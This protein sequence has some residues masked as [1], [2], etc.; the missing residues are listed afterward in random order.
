ME[1]NTQFPSITRFPVSWRVFPIQYSTTFENNQTHTH[2][3]LNMECFFRAHAHTIPSTWSVF[4]VPMQDGSKGVEL[5]PGFAL[6]HDEN[7]GGIHMNRPELPVSPAFFVFCVD[8]HFSWAGMFLVLLIVLSGAV[9]LRSYLYFSFCQQVLTGCVRPRAS[10]TTG[11][12]PSI[13]SPNGHRRG[14]TCKRTKD[15]V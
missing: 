12:V 13:C 11:S 6:P 15:F 5:K 2:H 10:I 7:V 4:F 8:T 3:S 14:R 9:Y 1:E